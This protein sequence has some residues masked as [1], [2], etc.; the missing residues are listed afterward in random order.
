VGEVDRSGAVL[1][2]VNGV[3]ITQLHFGDRGGRSFPVRDIARVVDENIA[4]TLTTKFGAL[5]DINGDGWVDTTDMSLMMQGAQPRNT[6]K[7]PV[8][9][10]DAGP[11]AP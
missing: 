9:V 7:K 3:P 2:T 4:P 11:M 10:N 5:P 6:A 1:V 8:I